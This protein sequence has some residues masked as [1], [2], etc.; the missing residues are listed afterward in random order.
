MSIICVLWGKF[1]VTLTKNISEYLPLIQG[2]YKR[3]FPF[4]ERKPF[5][6]LK[7]QK[8]KGIAEIYAAEDSEGFSGLAIT[9]SLGKLVLIDYIAVDENKR[10]SG[11]G[12]CILTELKRIYAG[13]MLFLEREAVVPEAKNA[14]QRKKR[15][16]F[17][18]R[19]GFK[20][21]G[22]P[23]R[24][25]GNDMTLMT[26]GGSV[27]FDEYKSFLKATLGV[28]LTVYLNPKPGKFAEEK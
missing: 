22:I 7:A 19:N 27:S 6:I 1:N 16:E 4:A 2:L 12:S 24:I 14:S 5:I 20:D 28:P 3:A 17:Y 21:T 8:R 25:Y 18:L 13:K 15:R 9:I 10:G 26:Y 11:A 23:V